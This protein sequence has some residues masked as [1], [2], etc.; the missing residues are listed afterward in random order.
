M[1]DEKDLPMTRLPETTVFPS[2]FILPPSS[3]SKSYAYCERL[4]RREAGNFYHGF[5]LL[6]ADQRRAMCALYAFMRIADDLADAPGP[7]AAKRLPLE[8]WR[9]QLHDALAGVYRHPIHPAL[10][11]TVAH[12]GVPPSYLEAV[13][14]GVV[15]DLDTDRYETFADLYRY[16]Y[17]VA[18]AVGLACIHIWGN[19]AE[20]ARRH[21][22]AAG[23][24][25]QLTNILRDLGEDAARGR[26]YLPREDLER[27]GYPAEHLARGVRDGPF[28]ELMRFEVARANAYY[29]AAAPLADLLPRAGRAVY[30]VMQRTYR[31]LLDRI[32]RRDYDVFSS[33]V[34]LSRLH[35]L[36]L[37]AR[38]LPVRLGWT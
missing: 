22:E 24:A 35:K 36:W 20:P 14:D 8:G 1:K 7:A 9:A 11:H 3:L 28:R 31:G 26:V 30:L 10:H 19:A 5:R 33:R 13:L 32:V 12:F 23:I 21:A 18:S 34:R 27:F 4:A 15:M 6:P 2:S 38:A 16:C 37:A 17:R 25:F 29:D